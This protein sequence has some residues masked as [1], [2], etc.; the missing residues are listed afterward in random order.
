MVAGMN[1]KGSKAHIVIVTTPRRCALPLVAFASAEEFLVS[2]SGQSGACVI[3][4]IGCAILDVELP[5]VTGRELQPQWA[6]PVRPPIVFVTVKATDANREIALTLGAKG[7]LSKPVR[8]QD[9]LPL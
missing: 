3:M 2:N 6:D 5:G 8:Y 1:E 7:F 9:S 4:D